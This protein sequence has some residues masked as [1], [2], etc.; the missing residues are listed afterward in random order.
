MA[1]NLDILQSNIRGAEGGY[2]RETTLGSNVGRSR[3]YGTKV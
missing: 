3:G 2:I 1:E